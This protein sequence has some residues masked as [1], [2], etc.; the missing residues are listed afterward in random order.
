MGTGH[1]HGAGPASV[2]RITRHMQYFRCRYVPLIGLSTGP[3]FVARDRRYGLGADLNRD[4][5]RRLCLVAW[6][7]I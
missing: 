3:E 5:I 2:L 4:T 7:S 1:E 6:A